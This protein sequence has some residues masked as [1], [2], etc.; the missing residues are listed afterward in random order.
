MGTPYSPFVKKKGQ[1]EDEDGVWKL[2]HKL[3]GAIIFNCSY[4]SEWGGQ[5]IYTLRCYYDIRSLFVE[6]CVSA[7]T[8]KII[9]PEYA[10][11]VYRRL[12]VT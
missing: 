4:D 1:F 12:L 2:N 7:E 11:R 3:L 6:G 10:V 5:R 9:Y 8:G